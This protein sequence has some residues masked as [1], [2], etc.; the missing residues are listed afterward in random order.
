VNFG[1]WLSLDDAP[2]LAPEAPGLMQARGAT[3]LT[4]P[5]GKS[6]MVLY[7]CSR[8]DETLR[9]YVGGRG[10]QALGRASAIGARFVRFG[11]ARA[12]AAELDRL[13][14]HFTDRFGAL[15]AANANA[16]A[17]A[18]AETSSDHE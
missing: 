8:P 18:D 2:A 3:L 17:D 6:A 15:P 4:Y 1:G 5:R 9:H 13:L 12:P 16:E 11:A 10:A 14:R 7:A